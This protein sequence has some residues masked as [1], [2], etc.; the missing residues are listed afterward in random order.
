MPLGRNTKEEKKKR[1]LLI[2]I[3]VLEQVP[4]H[5]VNSSSVYQV[6]SSVTTTSGSRLTSEY[7]RQLCTLENVSQAPRPLHCLL[8]FRRVITNSQRFDVNIISKSQKSPN[9]FNFSFEEPIVLPQELGAEIPKIKDEHEAYREELLPNPHE[10]SL[11]ITWAFI[12][13]DSEESPIFSTKAI[14]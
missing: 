13:E 10:D 8:A 6:S 11:M 3:L 4:R 7:K 1:A 5:H 14:P 2:K 12:Y 9:N